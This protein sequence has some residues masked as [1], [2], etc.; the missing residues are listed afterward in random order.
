MSIS[1]TGRLSLVL[2]PVATIGCGKSTTAQ[3]LNH[4]F[5]D[6]I[7]VVCNDDIPHGKKTKTILIRNC[8]KELDDKPIVFLDRNNHML[9]ERQQIFEDFDSLAPA[10]VFDLRF[11]CLNFLS[12][13]D[14]RSRQLW[15]ITT[16]RVLDRGDNHQSIRPVADGEQFVKKVMGG[17]TSRFQRVNTQRY[18]D[19]RFDIC[20]D[21]RVTKD[22]SLENAKLVYEA[23]AKAY[24]HLRLPQPT[25]SQWHEA[26][27][28]A[29]KHQPASFRK[30]FP[31]SKITPENKPEAEKPRPVDIRELL[32]KGS[33]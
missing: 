5:S 30:T 19:N 28:E 9:R 10:E 12:G 27:R 7:G 18:P 4:M 2:V 8:L 29:L 21:L 32:S 26:A 15:D 6:R 14:S 22:S 16:K 33:T 31:S 1:P 17:F 23:L 25:D 3:I 24:T 11:V 13:V 20:I